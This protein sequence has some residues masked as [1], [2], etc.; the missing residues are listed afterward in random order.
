MS[1]IKRNLY[2]VIG[3]VIALALM[4]LAGW[5]LY[6]NW[7]LNN[8]IL[9]KLNADYEQ[10]RKYNAQNPHPGV[11]SIN[12]IQAAK[13][14]QDQLRQYIQRTHKH[15]QR[16]SPIPD[17]PKPDPH[18]FSSALSRTIDQLSRDATNASVGLPPRNPSGQSYS[19]SF[20]AQ[21]SRLSF[22]PGS[23]EPLSVQL[24]EVK[25]IC[26]VL[27]QAKVNS[28]DYVHRERVC[29]EDATNQSD[30]VMDKST[31]NELAVLS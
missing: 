27:F 17:M 11:G 10:L 23:L 3:S 4:G 13:G 30:Y 14:Q 31:T 15:F 16:I 8:E 26:D 6:S 7:Q 9:E 24:G 21:R 12:N 5:Y 1:W 25:A 18:D 22:S 29:P 20:E 2:F 19:F 28:L